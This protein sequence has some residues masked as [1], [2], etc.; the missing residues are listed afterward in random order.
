[1]L[2]FLKKL[3]GKKD[4]APEAPPRRISMAPGQSDEEQESTRN[5]MESEMGASRAARDA[6]KPD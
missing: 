2:E 3:F 4:G 1:M 6:K 5:R